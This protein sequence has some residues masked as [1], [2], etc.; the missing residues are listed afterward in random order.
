MHRRMIFT[1]VEFSQTMFKNKKLILDKRSVK[2]E[3][4][5]VRVQTHGCAIFRINS[6]EVGFS[7]QTTQAKTKIGNQVIQ[8]IEVQE[9]LNPI[10]NVNPIIICTNDDFKKIFNIDYDLNNMFNAKR[11]CSVSNEHDKL[12]FWLRSV[13]KAICSQNAIKFELVNSKMSI[14]ELETFHDLEGKILTPAESKICEGVSNKDVVE[15]L[16]NEMKDIDVNKDNNEW[17]LGILEEYKTNYND[18]ISFLR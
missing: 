17:K 11:Y 9:A 6:E 10:K 4:E 16:E 15:M 8:N 12:Y 2:S 5:D 7:F 1:N 3:F 14:T 13:K 18:L